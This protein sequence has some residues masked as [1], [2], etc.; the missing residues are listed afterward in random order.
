RV[1]KATRVATGQTMAIKKSRA[2]LALKSTLLN[3]ERRVLQRLQGHPSIPT[4]FAYGRLE[5]FEYLAM[6]LLG[7]NLTDVWERGNLPAVETLV[8]ADQMIS[9][10]EHIHKNKLVHCD[11][12]PGNIILHPTDPKRLY[13]VDYGLTR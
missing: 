3:H 13:L 10:L 4:V 8:V 2:F 6:Q 5:H 12:K 9:A 11:L 1:Y 7:T